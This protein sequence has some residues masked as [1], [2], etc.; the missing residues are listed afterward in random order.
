V[1]GLLV[2]VHANG[3]DVWII[4]NDYNSNIFRAWLLTCNGLQP[5]PVVSTIGIIL[6][7]YDQINTG[8]IKISPNGKIL[9]QTHFPELN[10]QDTTENSF[11]LFDFNN[12]TGAIS[13]PKTITVPLCRYYACEFSPDSKL[14]YLTKADGGE[15]DQFDCTLNT[16][17]QI[18]ASQ[19]TITT[20]ESLC[21]LQLGPDGKIYLTNYVTYMSVISKPNIKGTGCSF[22]SRKTDL[23]GQLSSLNL[24]T[25]VNDMAID[26]NNYFTVRILDTCAG[27][28]QFTGYTSLGGV[29][30][31]SWNFG[32]GFTSTIQNPV[33]QFPAIDQLFT[34]KLK[35]TS[36]SQCG[37]I[38]KAKAIL[39]GGVRTKADFKI[40]NI[41]DSGYTRFENKSIFFPE[42]PGQYLWDFGDGSFSFETDPVHIY[43]T[44]GAYNVKLK[45]NTNA[46][47]L[48]DSLTK[49]L[50]VQV[51]NIQ[52]PPDQTIDEGQSIQLNTIG[53][54]TIFQWKPFHRS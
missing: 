5:N 21:G 30:Q 18:I 54:G 40:I 23:E 29:T 27:I 35:I 15:V 9:C 20:P 47:C 12:T 48:N 53:G 43:Q 46:A 42:D 25:F 37:F 28:V 16:E 22:K 41:C 36:S 10:S 45:I 38:E 51:L 1:N 8:D 39:P 6:N 32:D 52:A 31:W 33:H 24:P 7:Q 34:V 4:T 44:Q 2:P 17:A 19:F 14:L 13:N 26:I 11:Q 49:P 3:I 50:D